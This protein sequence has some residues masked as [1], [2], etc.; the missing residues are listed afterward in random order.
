MG[1]DDPTLAEFVSALQYSPF[2]RAA[3]TA[4]YLVANP[5]PVPRAL[6]HNLK[7]NLT[8]HEKNLVVT[9]NFADIPYV[10]E[11]H[12]LEVEDLGQSFWRVRMQFG[13]ME[14][15]D[16]PAA[17]EKCLP[18]SLGF[19]LFTASFFISRETVVSTA[20]TGMA[21]WRE[22]MFGVMSRNAGSVVNY[23]NLPGNQ[24][25]ELGARVHI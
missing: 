16:V 3:R 21:Q 7:H 19:K 18:P 6:L 2:P 15:P 10:D 8:L 22:E 11:E 9:V 12:R 1:K 14:E 13:F 20:G 5:K 25:I 23:F 4:V 17:L 24:V